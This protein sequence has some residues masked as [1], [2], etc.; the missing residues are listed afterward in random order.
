[1]RWAIIIKDYGRIWPEGGRNE[2]EMMGKETG[3]LH[4]KD[5][6]FLQETQPTNLVWK[7]NSTN[8]F[9]VFVKKNGIDQK[10]TM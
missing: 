3:N 1:M 2:E 8:F 10:R 5:K 9:L 4:W 7:G 6:E